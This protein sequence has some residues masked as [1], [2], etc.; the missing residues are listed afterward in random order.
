MEHYCVEAIGITSGAP[1]QKQSIPQAII[2]NVTTPKTSGSINNAPKQVQPTKE[3][4]TTE[5]PPAT[6]K[7]ETTK[8]T[9]EDSIIKSV[10]DLII[11]SINDK[12]KKTKTKRTAPHGSR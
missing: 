12:E 4:K 2:H 5:I 3:Q 11:K 8:P 10:E 9:R 1:T 7:A 6:E